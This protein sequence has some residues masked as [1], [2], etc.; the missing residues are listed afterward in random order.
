M[1]LEG[2]AKLL[3]IYVGETEKWHGKTLYKQ[4]VMKLREE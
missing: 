1:S 4:I 2:K 3:K